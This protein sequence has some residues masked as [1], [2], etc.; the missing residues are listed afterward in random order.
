MPLLLT[1]RGHI[2]LSVLLKKMV[3]TEESQPSLRI[4]PDSVGAMSVFPNYQWK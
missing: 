1:L 4:I 3:A 2:F